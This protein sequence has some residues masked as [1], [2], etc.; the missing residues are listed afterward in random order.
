MVRVHVDAE[1][2]LTQIS[3]RDLMQELGTR[4]DCPSEQLAHW[5][6]QG[7]ITELAGRDCPTAILDSLEEWNRMPIA[8]VLKLKRW[9]ESCADN[10][11]GKGIV[12]GLLTEGQ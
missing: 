9:C 12:S 11:Y 3:T 2:D 10:R 5:A 8:D 1:V 4:D 7:I 6:I